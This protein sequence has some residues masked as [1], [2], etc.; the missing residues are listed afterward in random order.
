MI[1]KD[2]GRTFPDLNKFMTDSGRRS[3]KNVLLA[4]AAYDQEVGYCQGMN[5]LA[6]M[7]LLYLPHEAEAFAALVLLMHGRGLRQLYT[8]DMSLLEVRLGQLSRL[9][10]EGLISHLE[11][12]GALPVIFASSWFLT[13]F[14]ANFPLQIAA[15]V[16]DVVLCGSFEAFLL[17]LSYTFLMTNKRLLMSLSSVEDILEFMTSTLPNW[18]INDLQDVVSEAV[19]TPWTKTQRS[20]L[21]D[22]SIMESLYDTISRVED[23]LSST[24]STSASDEDSPRPRRLHSRSFAPVSFHLPHV[25]TSGIKFNPFHHIHIPVQ[26]FV[27]KFR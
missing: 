4:Y 7:L 24:E 15:R 9:L 10:P 3:L 11:S 25:I 17:K 2:V 12:L 14:A 19:Q 18:R 8:R 1:E 5:F 6:G 21:E 22:T 26:F 27:R 16:M 23:A 13:C 20:I